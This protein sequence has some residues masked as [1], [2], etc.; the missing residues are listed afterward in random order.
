MET[1]I[2]FKFVPFKEQDYPDYRALTG[3]PKIMEMITG[4]P[5][6]EAESRAHFDSLLQQNQMEKGFGNFRIINES[7]NDFMGLAKLVRREKGEKEVEIGFMLMEKYQGKG[8]ASVATRRLIDFARKDGG[9]LR[10]KAVL[11]PLNKAS[12][13]ILVREGFISEFIGE[14]DG[15]PGEIMSLVL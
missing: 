2:A 15:L 9:I 7:N 8:I 10:V 11:D 4:G 3:N 12:R 6:S 13:K 5:L 14:I 1:S